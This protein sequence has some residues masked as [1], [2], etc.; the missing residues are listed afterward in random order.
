MVFFLPA[1]GGCWVKGKRKVSRMVMKRESV[2]TRGF[3][4]VQDAGF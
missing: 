1:F 4:F 3:S 2:G